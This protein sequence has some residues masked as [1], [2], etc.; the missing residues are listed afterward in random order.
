MPQARWNR[1]LRVVVRGRGTC[2]WTRG[3]T[4]NDSQMPIGH[5]SF[6]LQLAAVPAL[7]NHERSHSIALE[8]RRVKLFK[9]PDGC[10][11]V[12]ITDVQVMAP[13]AEGAGG[14]PPMPTSQPV[15]P[16]LL[17]AGAAAV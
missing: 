15:S 13:E 1:N 6:P 5:R 7:E 12:L 10:D 9:G 3:K 4:A 17:L 14:A 11:R 8:A 2:D 16:D